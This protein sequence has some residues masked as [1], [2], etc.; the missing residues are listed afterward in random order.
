MKKGVI[1]LILLVLVFV[2]AP[3]VLGVT[4]TGHI[5]LLAVYQEEG[6]FHG[7]PADVQLEIKQGSGR[8][9]LETIPLSKVDTQISTRFAK[10]IAC[11]YA[12]FDCSSYD[13]FYT[14]KSPAGIVGGPSAGGA[15]SALTVALLRDLNVDQDAAMT[16]TINSGE[17]IGPVGSLKEKIEAA[18]EAEI[19]TVLV[20]AVQAAAMMDSEN[21]TDLVE[22]GLS[23]GVEVVPVSTLGESVEALTGV[24]MTQEEL[25]IVVPES[26]TGLMEAVAGELCDRTSELLED[27]DVFDLEGK[28]TVDFDTVRA[29]QDALNLTGKGLKAF[30]RG[31]TYSAASYCFGANVKAHTL[32]YLLQNMSEAEKAEE[33][34]RLLSEIDDFDKL[35]ESR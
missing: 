24:E 25:D 28:K 16:G 34:S 12:E 33:Y 17:L 5:K 19:T 23:L 9:F 27:I 20:P 10:E 21:S 26:Y 31:D 11:K 8:V 22:Y 3:A 29:Q 7:S 18:G 14:I 32:L 6:E 1:S 4:S 35:T 13:F 15:I 30:E 2:I